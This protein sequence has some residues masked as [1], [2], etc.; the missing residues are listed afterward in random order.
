MVWDESVIG[1]TTV[2]RIESAHWK[3]PFLDESPHW[4][5][6]FLDESVMDEIPL[7]FWMTPVLDE[8]VFG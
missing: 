6:P 1:S 3:K 2:S 4:M 5:N 8:S 7:P